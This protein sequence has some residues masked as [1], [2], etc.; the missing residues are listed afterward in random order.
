MAL[1]ENQPG[2]GLATSYDLLDFFAQ[3]FYLNILPIL[4]VVTSRIGGLKGA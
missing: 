3:F 1:N 2:L 4:G